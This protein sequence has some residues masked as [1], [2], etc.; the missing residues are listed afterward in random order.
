MYKYVF[1]YT[2]TRPGGSGRGRLRP[3]SQVPSFMNLPSFFASA[4]CPAV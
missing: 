1:I 3:S 2:K 4:Y